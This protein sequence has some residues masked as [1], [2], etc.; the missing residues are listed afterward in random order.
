MWH[1]CGG[2]SVSRPARDSS[3]DASWALGQRPKQL[4]MYS[5]LM[6]DR[7][8]AIIH[9][10]AMSIMRIF[11]AVQPTALHIPLLRYPTYVVCEPSV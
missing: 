11:Y 5:V 8:R 3:R 2:L 6:N 10:N 4:Y 1:E 7:H 9:A